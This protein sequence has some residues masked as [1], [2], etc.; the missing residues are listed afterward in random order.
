MSKTPFSKEKAL[1]SA[2]VSNQIEGYAPVKDKEVLKKVK[3]YLSL[4]K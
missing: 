3:V 1:K 2:T 4:I